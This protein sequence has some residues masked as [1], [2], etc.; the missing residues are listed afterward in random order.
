MTSD[1]T[2]EKTDPGGLSGTALVIVASVIAA[3][4][5]LLFGYDTGVVAA[6]LPFIADAFTLDDTMKQVVTAS[7]LAGAGG[8]ESSGGGRVRRAYRARGARG[9][10]GKLWGRRVT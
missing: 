5:G 9:E 3:F 8:G 7:L 1:G 2:A 6:A 10:G 4:G